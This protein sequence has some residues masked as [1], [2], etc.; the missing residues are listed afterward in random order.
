LI[1]SNDFWIQR[2]K[3]KVF[4]KKITISEKAQEASYLVAELIA[5]K[6]ESHTITESL[7]IPACKIIESEIDKIPVSANTISRRVDNV[8]RR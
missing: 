4:E 6:M 5:Q 2:Q 7:V 8:T 1:T 3:R